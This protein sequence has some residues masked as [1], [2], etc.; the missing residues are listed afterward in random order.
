MIDSLLIE[1]LKKAGYPLRQ[2]QVDFN[3]YPVQTYWMP[4]LKDLVVA[5]DKFGSLFNYSVAGDKKGELHKTWHAES[6]NKQFVGIGDTP[7]EAVAKLYLKLNKKV[8]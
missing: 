8:K 7:E 3:V 4:T 5:C 1:K 6:H 2:R